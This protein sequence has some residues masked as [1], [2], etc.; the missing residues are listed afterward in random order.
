MDSNFIL[1]FVMLKIS[2]LCS[3]CRIRIY[4][5]S[6]HRACTNTFYYFLREVNFFHFKYPVAELQRLY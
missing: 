2:G 1:I 3:F 4:F 5:S 6:I